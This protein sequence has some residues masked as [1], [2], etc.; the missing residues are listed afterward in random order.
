[1][2]IKCSNCDKT[3]NVKDELS[4]KK[5]KCPACKALLT[6][7][8]IKKKKAAPKPDEDLLAPSDNICPN[9]DI[10]MEEGSAVCT[11]CGFN[12]KTGKKMKTRSS[13]RKK[14]KRSGGG[15]NPSPVPGA[16]KGGVVSAALRKIVRLAV[17]AAMAYFGFYAV[18]HG[19][20]KFTSKYGISSSSPIGIEKE[21]EKSLKQMKFELSKKPARMLPVIK[22]KNKVQTYLEKRKGGMAM[23]G[24]SLN[25]VVDKEDNIEALWGNYMTPSDTQIGA[26]RTRVN[27]FLHGFWKQTG[28]GEPKFKRSKV[29]RGAFSTSYETSIIKKENFIA[30][31]VKSEGSY[32]P[33]REAIVFIRKD[34]ATA[35][36][37]KQ[38]QQ[39]MMF[40]SSS[41]SSKKKKTSKSKSKTTKK[42]TNRKT[43]SK[44]APVKQPAA[45]TEASGASLVMVK[46]QPLTEYQK[47][48]LEKRN[49]NE[50]GFREL[51][52]KAFKE[53]SR[54]YFLK[55]IVD[56]E[57]KIIK[58]ALTIIKVK[59]DTAKKEEEER[60]KK[61]QEEIKKLSS[62]K[63]EKSK[64]ELAD[65]NIKFE[66]VKREGK[67]RIE[68]IE[69]EYV[70]YDI[71]RTALN[72]FVKD[73][74]A[75]CIGNLKQLGLGLALYS[76]STYYG[77][78]PEKLEDLMNSKSR[79]LERK[80]AFYCPVTG[81]MY[82][83]FFIPKDK[84][85]HR[86][87]IFCHD[88]CVHPDGGAILYRD[89]HVEFKS[90]SDFGKVRR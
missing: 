64:K 34:V 84:K 13:Q 68:K 10:E 37:V 90:R 72:S 58:A 26:N 55:K 9:C 28:C 86:D 52:S 7:P 61:L 43:A 15:Y 38:A 30:A 23:W 73:L 31:W 66:K 33:A 83:Y 67:E 81:K 8:V 62:K 79:I 35:D 46:K 75:K 6:I 22:S 82:T 87:Q 54:A 41:S 25:M 40:T 51:T 39:G 42:T 69:K 77:K 44:K 45:K 4:G 65:L 76:S 53:E 47:K 85:I 3:L 70:D 59:H 60:Q 1:M 16:A 19:Y 32:G 12:I 63:D 11:S 80:E 49:N 20:K 57:D 50:I 27:T 56:Q 18:M 21:I 48:L 89:G 17:I 88:S 29:G 71:K 74:K 5:I 36:L 24:E 78:L 2:K 14:K